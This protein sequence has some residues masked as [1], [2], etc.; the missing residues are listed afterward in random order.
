MNKIAAFEIGIILG[1][2]KVA[3]SPETVDRAVDERMARAMRAS[4]AASGASGTPLEESARASAEMEKAKA[5][6]SKNRARSWESARQRGF[7]ADPSD[8]FFKKNYSGAKPK[9]IGA[10]GKAGL[11]LGGLTLAG[12]AISRLKGRKK[13]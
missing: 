9:R 13:K 12:L 3:L 6:K 1:M 10:K 2:E 5:L 11:A 4:Q 7:K 8:A